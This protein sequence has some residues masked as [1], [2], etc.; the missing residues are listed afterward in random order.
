MPGARL[1]AAEATSSRLTAPTVVDV[2]TVLHAAL[3]EDGMVVMT[4][5]ATAG[6]SII[7]NPRG[8][9]NTNSLK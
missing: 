1:I 2:V 8:K 7:F 6:Q 5:T 3:T 4:G 9:D